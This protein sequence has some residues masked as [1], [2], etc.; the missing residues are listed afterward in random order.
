LLPFILFL[1]EVNMVYRFAKVTQVA[2]VYKFGGLFFFLIELDFFY[3]L[4]FSYIVKKI[5]LEKIHVI[6]LYNVTKIKGCE[7]T[8]I[9]RHIL[10][11]E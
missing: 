8:I 5:V 2:L 10:H 3:S 7:E 1:Y 9:H 4:F 11:C 6:K